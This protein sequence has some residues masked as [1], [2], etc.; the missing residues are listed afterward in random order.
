MTLIL[1]LR[2]TAPLRIHLVP[3]LLIIVLLNM[4]HTEPLTRNQYR[5]SLAIVHRTLA[6]AQDH[7][8]RCLAFMVHTAQNW[9]IEALIKFEVLLIRTVSL[10]SF[11]LLILL[12]LMQES[13][14]A[15]FCVLVYRLVHVLRGLD[16]CQWRV[17]WVFLCW[18]VWKEVH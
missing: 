4:L 10:Q 5:T 15:L 12:L 13:D 7:M 3:V 11:W 1:I 8:C 16:R 9:L 17:D 2:K 18:H 6:I 14:L